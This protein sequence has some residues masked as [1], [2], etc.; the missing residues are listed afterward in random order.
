MPKEDEARAAMG[1][2]NGMDLKGRELNV[3]EAK[4]RNNSSGGGS[5]RPSW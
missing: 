4:P 3:N 5:R 2:L 1:A